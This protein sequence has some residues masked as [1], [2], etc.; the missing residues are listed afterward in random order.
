MHSPQQALASFAPES[1]SVESETPQPKSKSKSMQQPQP[2]PQPQPQPQPQPL[3]QHRVPKAHE[4]DTTTAEDL[5]KLATSAPS[6]AEREQQAGADFD[7]AD[8]QLLS[9]AA[10][11]AANDPLLGPALDGVLGAARGAEPTVEEMLRVFDHPAAFLTTAA[12]ADAP[13][14][15]NSGVDRSAGAVAQLVRRRAT[16]V[17]RMVLV[18]SLHMYIVLQR[19]KAKVRARYA[20]AGEE[21]PVVAGPALP[22]TIAFG[23]NRLVALEGGETTGDREN[24][25]TVSD[26]DLI[27]RGVND[28]GLKDF[29]MPS[30]T[31]RGAIDLS[32]WTCAFGCAGCRKTGFDLQTFAELHDQ[33]KRSHAATHPDDSP[34]QAERAARKAVRRVIDMITIDNQAGAIGTRVA[35]RNWRCMVASGLLL[36]KDRAKWLE[37]KQYANF[38]NGNKRHHSKELFLRNVKLLRS[39]WMRNALDREQVATALL[40]VS[41]TTFWAET[42]QREFLGVAIV[43]AR[44]AQDMGYPLIGRDNKQAFLARM[45]EVPSNFINTIVRDHVLCDAF[46]ADMDHKPPGGKSWGTVLTDLLKQTFPDA[47]TTAHA[48]MLHQT[49]LNY[50]KQRDQH[51]QPRHEVDPMDFMGGVKSALFDG[52]AGW[53]SVVAPFLRKAHQHKITLYF[54][55]ACAA[56][57]GGDMFA[58]IKAVSKCTGL[59]TAGQ[60]AEFERMVSQNANRRERTTALIPSAG[61]GLKSPYA[62]SDNA[63]RHAFNALAWEKTVA[64]LLCLNVENPQLFASAFLADHRG[65]RGAMGFTI[66]PAA[67][68][69]DPH[70]TKSAAAKQRAQI[71]ARNAVAGYG[72]LLG[73]AKRLRDSVMLDLVP[74]R[75]HVSG[76]GLRIEDPTDDE[77]S[78]AAALYTEQRRLFCSDQVLVSLRLLCAQIRRVVVDVQYVDAHGTTMHD[79]EIG[80]FTPA[81]LRVARDGTTTWSTIEAECAAALMKRAECLGN[82]HH[83]LNS[84]ERKWRHFPEDLCPTEEELP[85]LLRAAKLVLEGRGCKGLPFEHPEL[86][87]LRSHSSDLDRALHGFVAA[88]HGA[89]ASLPATLAKDVVRVTPLY[90]R[91]ASAPRDDAED[92]RFELYDT[93]DDHALANARDSYDKLVADMVVDPDTFTFDDYLLCDAAHFWQMAE[94]QKCYEKRRWWQQTQ[95]KGSPWRCT[96]AK[97]LQIHATWSPRLGDHT[98]RCAQPKSFAAYLKAHRIDVAQRWPMLENERERFARQVIIRKQADVDRLAYIANRADDDTE[99]LLDLERRLADATKPVDITA[100][101][102]RIATSKGRYSVELHARAAFELKHVV[103]RVVSRFLRGIQD[104]ET[105]PL[106]EAFDAEIV[107]MTGGSAQRHCRQRTHRSGADGSIYRVDNRAATLR[108]EAAG[109]LGGGGGGGDAAEGSAPPPVVRPPSLD[110]PANS[111]DEEDD[112]DDDESGAARLQRHGARMDAAVRQRHA[113]QETD[114]VLAAE[115]MKLETADDEPVSRL[116]L[117]R[118]EPL[119]VDEA[120][121]LLAATPRTHMSKSK[122]DRANDDDDAAEPVDASTARTAKR[123]GGGGGGGM[124]G[125]PRAKKP[126]GFDPHAAA[127]KSAK[128]KRALDADGD[129]LTKQD[130]KAKAR[131]DDEQKLDED[132]WDAEVFDEFAWDA[133]VV[134]DHG[135][136]QADEFAWDDC[137]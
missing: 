70:R 62:P 16:I 44:S 100:L 66:K 53:D 91:D 29:C 37:G 31:G 73:S 64:A 48:D 111:S 116:I 42:R 63:L 128:L 35:C 134:V 20:E 1:A 19:A 85:V 36:E 46:P 124:R 23:A 45:G 2:P 61:K 77:L 102:K 49:W 90:L 52:A 136:D 13:P 17:R 26:M 101:R 121:A 99:K 12:D 7:A 40:D 103:P 137:E 38:N 127:A 81:S 5:A 25:P 98:C 33:T 59:R 72:T 106:F 93:I 71:F 8:R 83:V 56:T 50:G 54:D 28:L 104:D 125:A 27:A 57:E 87:L 95:Q 86:G 108:A 11:V 115:G 117:A 24:R 9:T 123:R 84:F 80:L 3:K 112:D 68:V 43:L 92:E 32:R 79:Q 122:K 129:A 130:R 113:E 10:G 89:D 131:R 69:F 120:A 67:R 47:L 119:S 30:V 4:R 132:L 133:E 78:A 51:G 126:R 6:L 65:Y 97:C 118:D 21:C 74:V 82:A 39:L 34:R 110:A 58:A 105:G 135:A 94:I 22:V 60:R 107:R 18:Y 109:L 75:G 76:I 88:I 55:S 41:Q 96:N 14:R 114:D 15:F